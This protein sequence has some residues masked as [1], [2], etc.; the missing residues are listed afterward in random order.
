MSAD[1]EYQERLIVAAMRNIR[2]SGRLLG[3]ID[4]LTALAESGI[5]RAQAVGILRETDL[6]LATLWGTISNKTMP[7]ADIG[8]QL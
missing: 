3:N 8:D 4:D 2:N 5:M 1:S 6:Y 7:E